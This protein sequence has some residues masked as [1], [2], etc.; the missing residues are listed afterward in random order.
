ME[1]RVRKELAGHLCRELTCMPRVVAVALRSV[2]SQPASVVSADP[3]SG[4][5]HQRVNP[6]VRRLLTCG[7]GCRGVWLG[8]VMH[9][10]F[11]LS[12]QFWAGVCPTGRVGGQATQ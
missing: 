7:R 8:W 4:G 2:I 3:V 10:L 9:Y 6:D 11:I 1:R 12:A 5:T